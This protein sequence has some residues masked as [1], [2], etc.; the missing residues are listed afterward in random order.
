MRQSLDKEA[1]AELMNRAF[2]ESKAAYSRTVV[3]DWLAKAIDLA[4]DQALKD[5]RIGRYARK[6]DYNWG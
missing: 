1:K 5:H 2:V 4:Y 6:R 3:S